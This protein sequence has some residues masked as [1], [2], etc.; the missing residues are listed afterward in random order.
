MLEAVLDELV[1][2][3]M[4]AMSIEAIAAR[5]GVSKATI[6]RWW[7]DKVALTLEALRELPELPEPDTGSLEDDLCELRRALVELVD[8]T[9]LGD[10][11][12]ALIAERR[13]SEHRE[14][15]ARYIAQRSAPFE[16]IVRRAVD[17]GEL[18]PHLDPQ[19]LAELF[20]SPLANS[21]LFH[22]RPLDDAE[23]RAVIGVVTAG[24]R[25]QE[26]EP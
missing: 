8:T 22:D 14:D 20:S 12:P 5:A 10:V 13:R 18:P 4:L 9:S 6:Y 1:E 21:I 25:A 16:V 11:L 7:P 15:I 24:A 26:V 17:R 19:L 3:G 23:W 2:H